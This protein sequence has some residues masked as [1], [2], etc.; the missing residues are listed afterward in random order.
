LK[1]YAQID[2]NRPYV[3][4]EIFFDKVKI[5]HAAGKRLKNRSGMQQFDRQRY[6]SH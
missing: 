5:Y 3:F 1:G 6:K 4:A 2:E